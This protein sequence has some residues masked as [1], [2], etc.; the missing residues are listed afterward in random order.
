METCHS[1]GWMG[2]SVPS[3]RTGCKGGSATLISTG[4]LHCAI[5][6]STNDCAHYSRSMGTHTGAVCVSWYA[7]IRS[8]QGA[9]SA[10]LVPDEGAHATGADQDGSRARPGSRRADDMIAPCAACQ[11][12]SELGR[13]TSRKHRGDLWDARDRLHTT[14]GHPRRTSERCP[15]R[16]RRSGGHDPP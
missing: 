6:T 14:R 10:H 7:L 4:E 12:W 3:A 13:R 15:N 16:Y 9:E 1:I 11:V 2:W 5:R 8:A